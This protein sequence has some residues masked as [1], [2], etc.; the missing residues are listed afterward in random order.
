MYFTLLFFHLLGAAVWTGGHLVLAIGVLPKALRRRDPGVIEAFES[1]F[2]PVGLVA[3]GAQVLTG[4]ELTRRLLPNFQLLFDL[5]NP[6]AVAALAKLSLL[7]LTA[8][9]ALDA[10]L[11][12]I[13]KLGRHNLNALAW[14]IVAVTIL[15]VAFVY[16]GLRFRFG[17]LVA[18]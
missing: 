12:I 5:N 8:G 3:L 17:G 2:E 13:P 1:R 9:L 6:L 14:H 15:S 18:P 16:V 10:R 7:M 11:R 4:L